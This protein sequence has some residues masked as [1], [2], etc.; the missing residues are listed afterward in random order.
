MSVI[1]IRPSRL[2]VILVVAVHAVAAFSFRFAAMPAWAW[3][4]GGI[5]VLSLGCFM[6]SRSRRATRSVALM[7]DGKLVFEPGRPE[8][9]ETK[10]RAGSVFSRAAVWLAWQ[11]DARRQGA[12]M[13]LPDQ[14]TAADW[15]TLQVWVRLRAALSGAGPEGG[16]S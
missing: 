13:V 2:L 1:E 11:G 6:F 7:D 12:L 5:C 15:R 9:F 14:L 4:G 8:E 16:F 10:L 3:T